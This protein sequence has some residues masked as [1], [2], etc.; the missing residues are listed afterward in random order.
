MP[1]HKNELIADFLQK[2]ETAVHL[3]CFFDV[4]EILLANYV[5]Y[6]MFTLWNASW[7]FFF[8]KDESNLEDK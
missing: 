1:K 5:L 2:V 8:L 7:H 4:N 3:T 6:I